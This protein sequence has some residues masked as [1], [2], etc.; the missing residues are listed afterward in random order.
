MAWSPPLLQT[1]LQ[2]QQ[3]GG[4]SRGWQRRE[5]WAGRRDC[6]DDRP[7]CTIRDDDLAR[8]RPVPQLPGATSTSRSFCRASFYG[9]RSTVR[10]KN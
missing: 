4:E 7:K 8:D 5:K 3:R 2:M 10:A 1:G 6:V 9:V